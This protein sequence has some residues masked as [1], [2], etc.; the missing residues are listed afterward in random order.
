MPISIPKFF[1]KAFAQNGGRQDVPVTGDTS[2]GRATYD[3]GFP[4]VTRV[5]IVAGGIPPFGTDF[6]GILYD[7]SAAIQYLQSGVNFPFDQDFANAIG[8]YRVKAIVADPVDPTI[9]WQNNNANNTLPPSVPN[10]W[11]QVFSAAELIKNPTESVRGMPFVATQAETNAGTDDSKMV[12]PK[13]LRAGFS[14][15]FAATGYVALP[16]F[17]GGL[18]I[19]WGVASAG[20]GSDSTAF[21]GTFPL[22]FPTAAYAAIPI[23]V[24]VGAGACF[25]QIS[26]LT[27][28]GLSGICSER[29]ANGPISARS[30]YYI[31][32]GK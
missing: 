16:T 21:T 31:A 27:N 29:S 28:S 22:M 5:P 2:G 7:L 17:L 24:A 12:T 25:L 32:L 6:N 18:I 3:T 15:V 10:G 8:G 30:V 4:P 23:P 19:Q 20:A 9:L 1:Q 11:E 14:A 26:T 13:K